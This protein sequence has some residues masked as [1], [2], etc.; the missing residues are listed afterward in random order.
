MGFK[1]R[2]PCLIFPKEIVTFSTGV[3]WE[4]IATKKHV[5]TAPPQIKIMFKCP[6]QKVTSN[7]QP[8]GN[9]QVDEVKKNYVD[10]R[11]FRDLLRKNLLELGGPRM[12]PYIE[13]I[14]G[15]DFPLK[16]QE[17]SQ[18]TDKDGT[19][20]RKSK[21]RMGSPLFGKWLKI[22]PGFKN[23]T[24]AGDCAE[25]VDSPPNRLLEIQNIYCIHII[26]S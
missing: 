26:K 10:T 15:N 5:T 2:Y 24:E 11:R 14:V 18:I 19:K 3:R 13:T 7:D 17:R 22:P 4:W 6:A 12:L 16:E 25:I 1:D 8:L 20:Y 23:F 21:A 9:C